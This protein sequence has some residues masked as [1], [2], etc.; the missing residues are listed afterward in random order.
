MTIWLLREY[1]PAGHFR[2]NASRVAMMLCFNFNGL[3]V[4]TSRICFQVFDGLVITNSTRGLQTEVWSGRGDIARY[5]CASS[6]FFVFVAARGELTVAQLHLLECGAD[7]LG[8]LKAH[9]GERNT[10]RHVPYIMNF[11]EIISP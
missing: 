8:I 5:A 11:T 1:I 7:I 10:F 6:G 2:I 4:I 3:V 9:D